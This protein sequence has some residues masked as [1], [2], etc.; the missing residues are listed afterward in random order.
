MKK[1]D[2]FVIGI[3]V[4]SLCFY[5]GYYFGNKSDVNIEQLQ[6]Q[7]V[8]LEEEKQDLKKN[9]EKLESE[10]IIS[11]NKAKETAKKTEQI[12]AEL[13]EEKT[14]VHVEYINGVEYLPASI[15]EKQDGVILS[16]ETQLGD[17][18]KALDLTKS[19]LSDTKKALEKSELQRN[20]DHISAEASKSAIKN[21]RWQGR[22]EGAGVIE[23]ANLL[24]KLLK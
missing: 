4:L 17:T 3:I 6:T 23:C 24:V 20:L 13:E 21:A 5:I 16:L 12:K 1:L 15:S 11:E 18:Q 8:K 2:I 7:I 9:A 19:A 22:F 14:K 10:A